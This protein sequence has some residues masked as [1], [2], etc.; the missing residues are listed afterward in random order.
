[1]ENFLEQLS[2]ASRRDKKLRRYVLHILEGCYAPGSLCRLHFDHYFYLLDMP[3]ASLS[4]S[5][6]SSQG[7]DLAST[8][9]I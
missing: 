3:I 4:H 6:I 8:I 5:F 9:D 7:L 1:M 2:I